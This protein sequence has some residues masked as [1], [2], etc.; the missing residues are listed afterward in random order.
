MPDIGDLVSFDFAGA[1]DA[2][3]SGASS[4]NMPSIDVPTGPLAGDL[5]TNM[6]FT[7]FQPGMFDTTTVPGAGATINPM[8]VNAPGVNEG[9]GP[10]F[11]SRMGSSLE[12]SLE[13][14]P[15]GGLSKVLGIGTGALEAYS[16][17]NAMKQGAEQQKMMRQEEN[18]QRE[19][20]TPAAQAGTQLTGAGTQALMGGDLPPELQSL[21]DKRK[22]ELR[23]QLR[24]YFA[25]AGIDV[26]TMDAE[27][28][29]YIDQQADVY[30][31]QL[32]QMLLQEGYQGISTAMGPSGTVGGTSERNTGSVATNM[33]DAQSAI[34]MLTGQQAQS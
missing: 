10:G 33:K 17:I 3:V 1:G 5:G 8:G 12:N 2:A 23:G 29:S 34:A 6:D 25:K 21:V 19:L 15:L 26:S 7:Q 13:K 16:T 18:R 24:S 11:A 22:E 28:E 9:G 30:K 31:S 20:A 4:F 14:D 27:F 32:A